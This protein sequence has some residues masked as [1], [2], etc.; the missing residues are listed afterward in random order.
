[1]TQ[2]HI[3]RDHLQQ[4]RNHN[5]KELIKFKPVDRLDAP[6]PSRT[7]QLDCHSQPRLQRI[8]QR[9][10]SVF[11]EVYR[12]ALKRTQIKSV[13]EG[14]SLPVC[15]FAMSSQWIMD[16]IFRNR[17]WAA[18]GT[19]TPSTKSC[20]GSA[21]NTRNEDQSHVRHKH[22]I[23]KRNGAQAQPRFVH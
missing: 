22:N 20:W 4:D 15:Q 21:C 7:G 13:N 23:I 9:A 14:S 12:C 16:R 10:C 6:C 17:T 19:V 5:A 11:A 3:H 2:P 18:P 1:M 8:T